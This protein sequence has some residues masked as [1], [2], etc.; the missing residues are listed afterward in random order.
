M[1]QSLFISTTEDNSGKTLVALGILELIL[2]KTTKVGFFR[3]IIPSGN[4]RR[5]D[6]VDLIIKHFALRQTYEE[7]FGLTSQEV[8][9]LLAYQKFDT[10]LEKIIGKYKSLES[11]CDFILCEDADYLGESSAF[12]FE[13]NTEIAK[14]LGCPILI[15]GNA[16]GK[17]VADTINLVR[18]A[19]EAYQDGGCQ[20]MGIILNKASLEQVEEL[21]ISLLK[22]FANSEAILA[23]IPQ[24]NK[25]SSPRVKDIVE[26]LGAEILYG[27]HRLNSLAINYLVVAMQMQHSLTRLT[28]NT[29]VITPGDRGDV[30][31][32]MLQAHQSVNY[33]NL[34]GIVL[35]TG[36]KPE[37]AIALLIDGLSDVIPIL[38]VEQDTYTTASLVHDVYSTITSE[39]EE[40]IALCIQMFEQ[41]VDL[42]KLETQ[43][44]DIQVKGMTPKRF[45]YNLVQR[46]KSQ[47]KHIVLPEG[48]EPRILQ[49]AAILLAQDIVDLTLIG[50]KNEIAQIINKEGIPLNVDTLKIIAP[51]EYEKFEQYVNTLYELRKAKGLT[52]E[53]A[54][55]YAQDVSYFGTLMVY[56]GDAD[57]MVSGAVHTTQH[58]IRPALQIV[59]TL[60]EFSIVSSVFLMCL[61]DRVLVYGDCA[62]NPNPTAEQLAEIAITSAETAQR[63][64]VEPK[65]ALLSYSSGTSGQGEEVEKVRTATQIAKERRPDLKLEGPIQYDAAVDRE[66]ASQKM[67][68]SEV[69]GQATV[70]VFPDLNTGNNTYKAVQRET[71][72]IAIGPILQGLKKPVND[73]SRG[74][75]VT[76]IVNT[77]VI[78]AIQVQS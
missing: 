28:E 20:V 36:Y 55:D 41:Y 37:P 15:L 63:F 74:C 12:E 65:V 3:P 42:E 45:T 68:G 31:I 39:D 17:T 6:N 26:Q 77:V 25:L 29:L 48:T 21:K 60:P 43:I 40:K 46:A 22:E 62:V 14:N 34:A 16:E 1:A 2:K 58:T 13:L 23:I 24:N 59:K 11:K 19:D 72:A 47:K 27:H 5:D 69:A 64:G 38:S 8:N 52:L 44:R 71:G 57:G 76:D 10:I 70:F 61:E 7:S 66:V 75:T 53:L 73:L 56:H 50:Q 32:G 33:P 67:P 35:S 18:I 4:G 78:T 51:L 30:I 9:E 54:R 49:A